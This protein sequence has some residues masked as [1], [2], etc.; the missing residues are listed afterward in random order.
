MQAV[1]DCEIIERSLTNNN[2]SSFDVG[3]IIH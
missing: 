2:R 1:F 3:L